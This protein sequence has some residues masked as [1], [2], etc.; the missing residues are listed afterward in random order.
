M[1]PALRQSSEVCSASAAPLGGLYDPR[2][3]DDAGAF[4]VAA[5]YSYSGG[6][7]RCAALPPTEESQRRDVGA[8]DAV[9]CSDGANGFANLAM[10]RGIERFVVGSKPGTRGA[11]GCYHIQNVNSL[12]A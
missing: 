4:Q 2:T 7:R 5:A 8:S 12:H 11:A 9:L 6:P 10:K 1:G 3:E